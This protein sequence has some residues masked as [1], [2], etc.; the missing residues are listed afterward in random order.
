[1]TVRVVTDS[2]A[3]IPPEIL[4]ELD[5]AVVPIYVVF[6]ERDCVDIGEDE[7]LSQ[8]EPGWCLSD[9]GSALTQGLRRH[10][11]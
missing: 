1:M 10:L 7:F 9:H 5:I 6:G 2:A 3:D 8:A 4:K 11:H